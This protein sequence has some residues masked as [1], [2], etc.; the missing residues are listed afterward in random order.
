MPEQKK[1]SQYT[2]KSDRTIYVLINP[3]TNEFYISHCRSDLIK[4]VFKQHLYGQRYQTKD[5]FLSLRKGNEHPCLFV[6]EEIFTTK[7]DAYNYVIV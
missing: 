3:V 5:S 2:E 4:D 1:K 6:L 7:V